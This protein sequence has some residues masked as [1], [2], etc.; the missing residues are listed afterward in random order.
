L[1]NI[2]LHARAIPLCGSDIKSDSG[3]THVEKS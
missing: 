2:Y 1:I 3:Q